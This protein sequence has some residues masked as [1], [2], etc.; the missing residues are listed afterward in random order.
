MA[1]PCPAGVRPLDDRNGRLQGWSHGL[2]SLITSRQAVG[3]EGA[4]ELSPKGKSRLSGQ[5]GVRAGGC[6]RG[7]GDGRV[8]PPEGR[9]V[10]PRPVCWLSLVARMLS[11]AT[12]EGKPHSP[13][14]HR[15]SKCQ[16]PPEWGPRGGQALMCTEEVGTGS[17]R[18]RGFRSGTVTL[19]SLLPRKCQLSNGTGGNGS[20][21][22]PRPRYHLSGGRSCPS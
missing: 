16:R 19:P 1:S 21:V 5:D 10:C 9:G 4:H 2:E 20:R 7:G 11:W 18:G 3:C 15:C 17:A 13:W 8:G 12:A 6:G 22:A 14:K